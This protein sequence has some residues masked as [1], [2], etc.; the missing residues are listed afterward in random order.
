M[1]IMGEKEFFDVMKNNNRLLNMEE[2]YL[3]AQIV[4]AFTKSRK[5]DEEDGVR[6]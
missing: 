5:Q 2:R 3:L 1:E 6:W 4:N